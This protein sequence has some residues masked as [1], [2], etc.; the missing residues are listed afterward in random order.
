LFAVM[1]EFLELIWHNRFMSG[2]V[3]LSLTDGTPIEVVSTGQMVPTANGTLFCHSCINYPKNHIQLWGSVKIDER[4]SHWRKQGTVESEQMDNV[5]LHF[6]G[7][8]DTQIIHN[9]HPM[10]TLV[11]P[12]TDSLMEAWRRLPLNCHDFFDNLTPL[13]HEHILSRL[14]SERLERKST[15]VMTLHQE[16][17]ESWPQ[18]TYT[19]LLRSMGYKASK[20]SYH[21]LARELPYSILSSYAHDITSLEA[22]LMGQGGLLHLAPTDKYIASLQSIYAKEKENHSLG[23]VQYSWPNRPSPY[24]Q[25]AHVAAIIFGHKELMQELVEATTLGQMQHIMDSPLSTYW[26]QHYAPGATYTGLSWGI[27]EVNKLIINFVLPTLWSYGKSLKDEALTQR[28]LNLMD[29]LPAEE[30]LPVRSWCST[31][32]TPQSAYYSQALIQLTTEYCNKALCARCPVGAE[33]LRKVF[34]RKNAK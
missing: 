18:T 33:Y 23:N 24:L 17:H 26:A 6:V 22:L 21:R 5:I 30:Y 8:C 14:L 15:E 11:A 20:E 28:V 2:G 4:S 27:T 10:A 7:Q 3:E 16:A 19:M 32:Y 9:S 13:E 31:N 29:E 25:L 34:L 1:R 12:I